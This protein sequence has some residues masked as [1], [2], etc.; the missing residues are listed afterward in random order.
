MDNKE[1]I[2]I[3]DGIG[4]LELKQLADIS[5]LNK[6]LNQEE[7]MEMIGVYKKAVDRLAP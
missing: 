4:I 7:F 1:D 5:V 2:I 6:A 3:H